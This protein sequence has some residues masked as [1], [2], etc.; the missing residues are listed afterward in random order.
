MQSEIE[1]SFSLFVALILSLC[2]GLILLYY[3]FYHRFLNKFIMVHG[4]QQSDHSTSTFENVDR[5]EVE[6]ETS[7]P[8]VTT[9]DSTAQETKERIIERVERHQEKDHLTVARR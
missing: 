6:R 4:E 9:V 7:R 1:N 2:C 3:L 5:P 8:V